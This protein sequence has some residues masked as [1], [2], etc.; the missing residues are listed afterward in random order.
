MLGHKLW[1]LFQHRFDAWVAFRKSHV[2]FEKY[3]IF[4][5]DRAISGVDAHHFDTVIQAM[6]AVHPDIVINCIGII[7][8]LPS[9]KDP[10][11]SLSI[12]SLFPHRLARLCKAT[13]ARLIHISTDCVFSGRKGMY[14]EEDVSDAED[15]YGRTK[16]LG[17]LSSPGC[18]TLRTSIIGR[19]LARSTGLV[20]WF[21]SNHGGQVMG[22]SK[23]IYSGFTTIAFANILAKILSDQ[24]QLTGLYQVS[25]QPIS[26]FEL[27]CLLNEAYGV[28]I[29]IEPY[30]DIVLDRSLDSERFWLKLESKPPSWPDMIQE[31]ADDKTQ[32]FAWRD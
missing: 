26:K 8:Q 2:H 25:T 27:L 6:A 14:K 28:N 12:N 13:N 3:Q 17:E 5:P 30:E 31:M 20:E 22:Y 11:S 4:D 10:I 16:F 15:L 1:Q 9:A 18:L 7:K 19:E 24:P 29:R 32:Y 21:L 23:A